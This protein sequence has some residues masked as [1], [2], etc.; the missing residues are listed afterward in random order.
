MLA[1]LTNLSGQEQTKGLVDID[2]FIELQ[3]AILNKPGLSA[4]II[5]NDSIV[6]RGN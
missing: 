3:M 4:C 5:K 1:S 6:W 2:E